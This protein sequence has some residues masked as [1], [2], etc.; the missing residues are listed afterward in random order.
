MDWLSALLGSLATIGL[1]AILRWAGGLLRTKGGQRTNTAVEQAVAAL[2]AV[3][4]AG[5]V[6]RAKER[7]KVEAEKEQKV[8]EVEKAI[9][10]ESPEAAL[11]FIL[12]DEK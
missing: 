5:Q 9:Q 11:A 8:R 1:A 3:E 4:H 7:G 2:V 12:N 6:E 10:S